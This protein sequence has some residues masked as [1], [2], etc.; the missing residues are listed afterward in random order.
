MKKRDHLTKPLFKVF[1]IHLT[2]LAI[3]TVAK[4][5]GLNQTG[6]HSGRLKSILPVGDPVA[7]RLRCE[8]LTNPL[9]ID[10]TRPRLSWDP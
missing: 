8:Y 5:A 9:G 2:A 10:A 7:D 3:G 4:G 6:D 1:A